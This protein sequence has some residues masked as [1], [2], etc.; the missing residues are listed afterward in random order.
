MTKAYDKI[1][2]HAGLVDLTDWARIEI[3]GA[4]ARE[5]LDSVVGGNLIDLF[6]GRAMNTLIPSVEGGV[7]AIL[8][9]IAT[10]V[11]FELIAEP[12]E[13]EAIESVLAELQ[14][15]FDITVD[16]RSATR[17]HLV[18]TGPDAEEIA[19]E[20]LGDGVASIAFLNAFDLDDEISAARIGFFGEYELHLFGPVAAKAAL[21]ER[22]VAVGGDGIVTDQEAFPTMMA[23]MR[24]LNRARDIQPGASVF[25]TGLQ[26]MIDFQKDNLR[27][28]DAL[29]ARRE[30]ADRGC[31]LM[32]L[33]AAPQT[34]ALSVDG[35]EIGHVQSAYHS[36]TLGKTV[37]LAYLDA[38]LAAPGLVL[39][40]S[41]GLAQTVSAPAFLSRSVTKALGHAA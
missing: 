27:G 1:R 17:F 18:L 41:L 3:G 10:S 20:A 32:V 40:T 13:A 30:E 4:Q 16:D 19:S 25:A 12:S 28:A 14:N 35:E 37:A 7:E 38:D 39:Q 24:I 9:V 6:D 22:L 11:G 36:G 31:V 21:I 5:A 34:G 26:W 23:E 15:N 2:N 29:S 8:W 33:D